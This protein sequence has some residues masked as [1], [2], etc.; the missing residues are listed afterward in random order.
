MIDMMMMMVMMV[1]LMVV[2]GETMEM[3]ASLSANFVS[4]IIGIL[5]AIR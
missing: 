3:I 4:E 1:M 2:V 5:P